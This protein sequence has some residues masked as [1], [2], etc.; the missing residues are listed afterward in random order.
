MTLCDEFLYPPLLRALPD[1]MK[2]LIRIPVELVMDGHAVYVV[3]K[4]TENGKSM[5]H[6]LGAFTATGIIYAEF[7]N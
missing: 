7:S 6:K 1:V 3:Q 4:K 5:V 2:P